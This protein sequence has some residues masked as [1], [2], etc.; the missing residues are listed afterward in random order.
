MSLL[1]AALL[2]VSGLAAGGDAGPR[3]LGYVV[4]PDL[5]ATLGRVEQVASLVAPGTLPPGALAAGLG[6]QLGDPGLVALGRGPVVLI[7]RRGTTPQGPPSVAAFIPTSSPEPYEKTLT[8]LGWSVSRAPGLVM[9][10]SGKAPPP[11]ADEYRRLE[12]EPFAGDLR[13]SVNAVEL[14]TTYGTAMQS[15]L[16]TMASTVSSAPA[17]KTPGAPAPAS[18]ARLLQLEAVGLLLLLD[19]TESVVVDVNLQ[20]DAVVSET[21][22]AARPGSALAE[23]ASHAPA[24]ANGAIGLLSRPSVMTAAYQ[25]DGARVSA[26]GSDLL[27]RAAADP[28]TAALAT[29]ELQSLLDQWGRAFTGEAAV[30]MR[31]GPGAPLIAEMLLKVRDEALALAF[32]EKGA[33]LLAP[34]GSW[35]RVYADLGVPM[36]VGLQKNVR[37]HVAVAVH[38]FQMKME[39]KDLPADQQAQLALFVRDTDFAF[40]HGYLVSAQD[41][42]ALDGLLDRVLAARAAAPPT[43][44]SVLAF[45]SGAHVYVDYDVFGLLRSVSSAMPTGGAA[46]PFAALP[47]TDAHPL[48]YAVW[49]ADERL[50]VQSKL[51][52]Q[53]IADLMKAFKKAEADKK[54]TAAKP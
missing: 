5:R 44:Q 38:R 18:I 8:T 9:G 49:L 34:G 31:S 43:L 39:A 45:G 6:A 10:S 40:A 19:Q 3:R 11:P 25:L 4:I 33:A 12:A 28:R 35:Q 54:V 36:H 15:A 7:L 20:P 1:C 29:P 21:V 50:R 24:G 32:M 30:A 53:P 22:I 16:D 27:R 26:F 46:N 48:L 13:L 2:A 17:G 47:P 52:L 14:M 23:L 42:Q 37:R 51:P 41:P